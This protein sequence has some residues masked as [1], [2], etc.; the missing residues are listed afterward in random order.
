L[1][2]TNCFTRN[3]RVYTLLSRLLVYVAAATAD[4]IR[5]AQKYL[6]LPTLSY[7]DSSRLLDPPPA[8]KTLSALR[9]SGAAARQRQ[10]QPCITKLL[11][12]QSNSLMPLTLDGDHGGLS[13]PFRTFSLELEGYHDSKLRSQLHQL[14]GSAH[15]LLLLAIH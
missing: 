3:K 6:C 7:T 2:Q 5:F 4:R 1:H 12:R 9:F 13:R 10:P 15:V 11:Y 8:V 14:H